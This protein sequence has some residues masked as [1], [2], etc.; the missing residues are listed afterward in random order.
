MNRFLIAACFGLLVLVGSFARPAAAEVPDRTAADLFE[1]AKVVVV[2]RCENAEEKR[3]RNGGYEESSWFHTIVVERVEKDESGT[4][5]PGGKIVL[6][7]NTRA[8]VGADPPPTGS[9][10][11]RGIPK[12]GD[13]V[14]VFSNDDPKA[15]VRDGIPWLNV[16]FPNGWREP[17]RHVVLLGADDEYRSE[18]TMP[19]VARFLDRVPDLRTTVGVAIDPTTKT[20]D[21]MS[22]TAVS[23]LAA[24]RRADVAVVYFRWRELGPSDRE[25]FLDFLGSG[26]PIVGLRTSTHMLRGS[27]PEE[28]S[29]DD[30]LAARLWGQRWISH[31]GHQTKTRILPPE[32]DAA[33]HPILRGVRGDIVVRSWLY[34]V[35]PLPKDCTVL[36]WGEVVGGPEGTPARQ[37]IVWIRERGPETPLPLGDRGRAPRRMAFTTLGHPAD[38]AEP[39]V[40]RLV[41][42]LILWAGGDDAEIPENGLQLD[43]AM[44]YAPPAT[45]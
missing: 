37:P 22:R 17:K 14:R 8:W 44:P 13:R 23:E 31:H 35:E 33:K 26:Q 6:L 45:R 4:L 20:P 10:G 16:A 42:H 32:G 2:G 24:L 27:T 3:S 30:E 21:P 41:A 7:S 9:N 38:F 19:L 43:P 28:Q 40:L 15:S 5:V 36:L 12:R 18:I 1:T 25:A 11:H 39:D 34:D 29:K